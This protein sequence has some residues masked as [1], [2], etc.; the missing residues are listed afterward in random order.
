MQF[1]VK[2]WGGGFYIMTVKS[3]PQMLLLISTLSSKDNGCYYK[4]ECSIIYE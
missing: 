2:L 3:T 4:Y 1:K